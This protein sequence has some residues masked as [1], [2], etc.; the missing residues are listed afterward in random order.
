MGP[1]LPV[2]VHWGCG[3]GQVIYSA[4][5]EIWRWRYGRG[6]VLPEQFWIQMIRMLAR[7]RLAAGGESAVLEVDPAR[8]EIG[9]PVQVRL[10]ILDA[11]LAEV[12]RGSIE[13][14][15]VDAS[16]ESVTR[17]E[18]VPEPGDDARLTT[19]WLPDRAGSFSVRVPGGDLAD[20]GLAAG[21]LVR[22]PADELLQPETD[23]PL[24]ERLAAETGGRVLE[25]DRIGPGL[26]GLPNREVRTENPLRESIWDTP[27]AFTLLL[28]LLA[29]EWLGRRHLRLA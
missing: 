17:L 22:E 3:P 13:V 15:V 23:H 2:L 29:L 5:D 12:R 21:L 4:T 9:R 14:E 18:L 8:T 7:D 16:G 10:R 27:L 19:T 1:R 28:G 6:E 24:L 20:L 25:P 26:E 11:R